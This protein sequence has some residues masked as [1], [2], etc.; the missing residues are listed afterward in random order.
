MD[1]YFLGDP[2][3]PFDVDIR[4]VTFPFALL[5]FERLK[6]NNLLQPVQVKQVR[7]GIG[8]KQSIR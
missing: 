7:L 6:W 8:G 3:E 1:P 5:R 4:S 2:L